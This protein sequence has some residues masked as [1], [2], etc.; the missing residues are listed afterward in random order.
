MGVS[1][2]RRA[3][4]ILA[5][6]LSLSGWTHV[7]SVLLSV[8]SLSCLW[9]WSWEDQAFRRRSYLFSPGTLRVVIGIGLPAAVIH[10]PLCAGFSQ[11][12]FV[13]VQIWRRGLHL[14]A[15]VNFYVET[16]LWVASTLF[17]YSFIHSISCL[18]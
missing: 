17:I 13:D 15:S 10:V 18:F 11:L 6:K 4:R 1:K 7:S 9:G 14:T 5:A 12:L 3:G 2:G 8:L 16:G